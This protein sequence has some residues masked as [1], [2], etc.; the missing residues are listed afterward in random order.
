MVL[1]T[2]RQSNILQDID[3]LH[4][5]AQI[6]SSICKTL[7]EREILRNAFELLSAFDELISMGYR[8]NL[9]L[10][11]VKTNL[12]MESHEETIQDIIAR[13]KMQD[14]AEERKRRAKQFDMQR[15][16]VA[17]ANRSLGPRTTSF[18][19]YTPTARATVPDTY[20]TYE[21]ERSKSLKVAPLRGKG[22]QLGKKSKTSDIYDKVRGEMGPETE[23]SP[24]VPS[25]AASA[26]RISA[27]AATTQ[28]MDDRGPVH[29]TIAE[30]IT[31]KVSREGSPKS[32]KVKG[33]LQLRI[34]DPAFTRV[35]VDVAA[36]AAGNVHFQTHPN[37]DKG[38]FNSSRMIQPKNPAKGFPAN[39]SVEVL[40]WNTTVQDE[41]SGAL[42][43][44]F[45][46]WV[47]QGT[48]NSYTVTVEYELTGGDPLRDVVVT[49]PFSTSEPVVSS[50]DAVYEVSGD[51]LDWNIGAIGEEN[52]TGSF[53]FEAQ[54][55]EDNEFFPMQV[56]FSKTKPFVDIDVSSI[57]LLEQGEPVDFSKEIRSA[58]DKYS[59]E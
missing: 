48:G 54:A 40:R 41:E 21:A 58:S 11:Q 51:S 4:L 55:E 7:E 16:E 10:S 36:A 31:V 20:D 27:S 56:R 1:I 9:T 45:T 44:T 38:L 29:V 57:T 6:V 49:I 19:T 5:F 53:E 35:K 15:K 59:I 46:V 8:E 39:S 30:A 13:N 43:I 52:S 22:M 23:E 18:P 3:S 34:L 37:V 24:L 33:D 32:F 25:T 14:A 50:H 2:N 42:P 17:R 47:N 12:E 26:P 28:L